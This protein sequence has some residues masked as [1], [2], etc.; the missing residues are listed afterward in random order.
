MNMRPTSGPRADPDRR[1]SETPD[2]FLAGAFGVSAAVR[3]IP[4]PGRR[5][6]NWSEQ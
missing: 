2:E 3:N 6:T 4:D 1:A 5:N